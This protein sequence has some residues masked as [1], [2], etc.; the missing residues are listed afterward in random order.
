MERRN[1]THEAGQIKKAKAKNQKCTSHLA[2]TPTLGQLT[3]DNGRL[4]T[5]LARKMRNFAANGDENNDEF[6]MMDDERRFNGKWTASEQLQTTN[7]E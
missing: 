3:T 4:T 1:R 2:G 5:R 6:R 7:C